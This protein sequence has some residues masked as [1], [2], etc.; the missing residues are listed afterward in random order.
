MGL[1]MDGNSLLGVWREQ[2]KIQEA[3]MLSVMSMPID[4]P[5]MSEAI[6]PVGWVT[7]TTHD[8]RNHDSV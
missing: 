4:L 8:R 2:C 3:L 6:F 7:A 1:L 5:L